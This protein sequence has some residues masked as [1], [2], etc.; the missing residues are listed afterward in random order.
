M[1]QGD[2]V[3]AIEPCNAPCLNRAELRAQGLL[4]MLEP[5]QQQTNHLEIGVL[6]GE[7]EIDRF[8]EQIKGTAPSRTV[9]ETRVVVVSAN[10]T[11]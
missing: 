7:D 8:L 5:G 9:R 10:Q 4:P 2:Y 3:M 11:L 6:D 1:G